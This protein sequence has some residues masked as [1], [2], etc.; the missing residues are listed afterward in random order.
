[1][2]SRVYEHRLVTSPHLKFLILDELHTYRGRQGADVALLVRKLR[3]RSKQKL[4]CI[5]TSATMASEGTIEERRQVVAEV[6]SKLFGVNI[7]SNNVIDETLV[8]S[9]NRPSPSQAELVAA[10]RNCTENL[11]QQDLETYNNHPLVA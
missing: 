11:Q 7:P 3:Q 5:G 10:I 8:K 1:M 6:A 4:I 2:L 9:I